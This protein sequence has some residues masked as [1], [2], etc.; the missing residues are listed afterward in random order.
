VV[1]GIKN[2]S[3]G[4]LHLGAIS[5]TFFLFSFRPTTDYIHLTPLLALSS[6]CLVL[7]LSYYQKYH[8]QVLM[9]V[10]IS[11]LLFVGAYSAL[12]RNYYG[13]DTP[14]IAHAFSVHTPRLGV[15]V[16]HKT[17][18]TLVPL[19]EY[20]EQKM[21]DQSKLFVYSFSPSI[22]FLADKSNPTRYDYVH[23]GMLTPELE[24]SVSQALVTPEVRLVVT[25]HPIFNDT[26]LIATTI[27]DAFIPV[28]WFGDFTVWEKTR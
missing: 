5:L 3:R 11:L 1:S 15:T 21:K 20:L 4:L 26:S 2:K 24:S 10:S 8:Q 23:S 7:S 14:L 22:Y 6:I 13:W 27:K 19:V 25:D 12:F 17:T 16:D 9:S 18:V 28:A